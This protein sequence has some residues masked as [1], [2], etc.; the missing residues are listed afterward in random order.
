MSPP[1]KLMRH[2]NILRTIVFAA[3][4]ALICFL[5]GMT[6]AYGQVNVTTYHND[7]GRTGQNTQ[8]TVL[9]PRNVNPTHFKKMFTGNV[10]LD[11]WAP[12][13]PLYVANVT[14]GGTVHNVVYVATLNNSIY[15]FDADN[16]T[17]LWMQNYG[18]PTSF[19]PLCHDSAY[20]TSPSL[21][22]G[23]IG[24]P[25]IDPVAGTIYFVAKTGTGATGS[26]Y[27]LILHA[28]DYTSGAERSGSP[29]P[30]N[31]A[32]GP[33]FNPRLQ[34]NRPGL[35][36]SNGFVYV[37]LGST[38]CT[39]FMSWPAINNHGYVLGFNTSNLGATPLTFVTTPSLNNGGIWQAGGGLV[40]D[41]SGHIYFET[42]DAVFDQNTGGFDFGDSIVELD[43]NL[44]F[45]DSFTPY[46]ANSLLNPDDLDLGSVGPVLLPDQA[47]GPPHLLVGSGKAE[48]I[49]VLNRDNMGGFCSTCTTTNTNIV[50]DIQRPSYLSG[51]LQPPTG[52]LTC[53]YGALSYWNNTLYVPGTNAP[54][55]SYSLTNGTLA[56]TALRSVQGYGNVTSPSISANG[57]LNGIVWILTVGP[58]P[59]NNGV[60]RAFDAITLKILYSSSS[61]P[62]GR[63]TL[64]Q[65]AHFITPTVA[66]GKVYV[67]T[68]NQLVV[69]GHF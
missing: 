62:Y 7:N 22:A 38:G 45:V 46:D 8:E 24:T 34:E 56:T 69:Y 19:V 42:S 29:V 5:G 12:A 60:L 20:Q 41:S 16:G 50:Q 3:V 4:C 43:A 14:I 30:V 64:G 18:P 25:V 36:L 17:E 48:E 65:V 10:N 27:A 26:P 66:N 15:A 39:G 61:A 68:H 35:L 28:V 52:L 13:Q 9:T 11:S 57:A 55:M 33:K 21:G 51:C 31:P 59:A 6:S 47:V 53:R 58:P 37:G 49:Y 67:A 54:L 32:F 63:D 40:A 44:N 1:K 23:I 2:M